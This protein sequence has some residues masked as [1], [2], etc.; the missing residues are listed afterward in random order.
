MK[1]LIDKTAEIKIARAKNLGDSNYVESLSTDLA[2]NMGAAF[3][4]NYHTEKDSNQ[5]EVTL[6]ECGCITDVVKLGPKFGLDASEC[7]SIFCG[8]CMGGYK[9]ASEK[10]DVTF[11]GNLTKS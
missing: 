1:A 5:T 8:S 3:D 2:T 4:S 9:A 11:D 7:R 6:T 10:L